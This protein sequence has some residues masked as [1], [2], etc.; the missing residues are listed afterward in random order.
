MYPDNIEE[1]DMVVVVYD[2]AEEVARRR[3]HGTKLNAYIVAQYIMISGK[4]GDRYAIY[5]SR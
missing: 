4:R 2:H 5:D 1:R 3:I